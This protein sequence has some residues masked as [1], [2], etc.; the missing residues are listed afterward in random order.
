M[1]VLLVLSL[2]LLVAGCDTDRRAT[3]AAPAGSTV[4]I[5]EI[6]PSTG[7]PLIKGQIVELKVKVAYTLTSES[8]TLGLV[9]QDASN[10][11]LAQTLNVVLKGSNTET[12][13]VNFTVPE[14]K[15]VHVFTPLSSQGQAAT[16]TVSSRAFKVESP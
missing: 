12:F 16:S 7:V 14:T 4:S 5:V 1:R 10:A 6:Q 11:S 8:G 2:T 13:A 15:A 9:V 3:Q